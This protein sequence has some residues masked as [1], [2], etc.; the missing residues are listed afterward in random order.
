MR[1][2]PLD[3][4]PCNRRYADTSRVSNDDKH[5]RKTKLT[6]K[7]RIDRE[8]TGPIYGS[9]AAREHEFSE[10]YRSSGDPAVGWQQT[11]P[12]GDGRGDGLC[13]IYNAVTYT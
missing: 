5:G 12:S 8:S 10:L 1:P 11:S 13:L 7:W 2:K 9:S 4:S 6:R 3:L